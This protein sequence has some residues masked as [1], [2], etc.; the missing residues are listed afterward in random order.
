MMRTVEAKD[1]TPFRDDEI[2]PPT[3]ETKRDEHVHRSNAG[4]YC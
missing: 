4:G 2:Y 1:R 3:D